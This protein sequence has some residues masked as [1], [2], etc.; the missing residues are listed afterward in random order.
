[1][2]GSSFLPFFAFAFWLRFF[3]WPLTLF[4]L[5]CL[6]VYSISNE[7]GS[8]FFRGQIVIRGLGGFSD[9]YFAAQS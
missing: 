5:S 1:M 6:F 2:V 7:G 3:Y 4:T 9:F 8:S